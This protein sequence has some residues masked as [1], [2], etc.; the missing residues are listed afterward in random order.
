MQKVKI[1]TLGCRFNFDES[2]ISKAIISCMEPK[3]DVVLVNTCSVTHEAERQSKQAVRKA[4]RENPN[5]T[6]IVTGCAAKTSKDYFE[7][8][9]GV[10]KVI[11]ND[12]KEDIEEYIAIPHISDFKNLT[13]NEILNRARLFEDK[14]RAFLQVQNGCDHFCSYCIVPFTRGRSR[15]V[16]LS[17]IIERIHRFVELGFK[18]VV[19]SGI[20]ITSYG[21]D[22][23]G[24]NLTD[25]IK[26]IIDKFPNLRVRISS[27]DPKGITDDL[28]DLIT[29]EQQI[30]PHF[31]LSIQ[32]GSNDVLKMMK[33]RHSREDVIDICNKIRDKRSD[34]VFGCDFIAGFPSE[35]ELMFND[36]LNL[37]D[38][39][40]LSLMHVFPY[41][42]RRGTLAASM[43][44]LPNSIITDRAKRLRI[45]SK[46]AKQKLFKNL[47]GTKMQGIVEQMS[48]TTSIGK[49][50]NFLPFIINKNLPENS[51]ITFDV[52]SYTDDFLHGAV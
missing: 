6:V 5:A 13:Q 35:T 19:L 14:T 30:M 42:P 44:Q 26:N 23:N 3:N 15:S 37:I 36:T 24:T 16:T 27:I 52:I 29:S 50:D 45:K 49:T 9:D 31:H 2:E 11:Q 17:E 8:L 21:K 46:E 41:S 33:R 18:E 47:V 34:V 51:L 48:G 10:F 4:I 1:I 39:A 25:V 22:L 7:N 12:K 28:L 32:S 43:V 38:E 40:N 20:D